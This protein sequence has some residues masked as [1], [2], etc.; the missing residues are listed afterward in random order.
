M[1]DVN[2][3]GYIVFVR[4]SLLYVKSHDLSLFIYALIFKIF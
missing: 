3:E 1:H 4:E 2:C